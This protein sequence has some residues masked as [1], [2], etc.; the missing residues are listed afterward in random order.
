MLNIT[1][2]WE[3][4]RA[5]SAATTFFKPITI[6]DE[7]FIDGATG[8]NNPVRYMLAEARDVFNNGKPSRRTIIDVLSL[9]AQAYH[10]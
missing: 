8:A 10:R 1:K 9:S 7:T 6:G 3:A 4:A 5:T 2:I